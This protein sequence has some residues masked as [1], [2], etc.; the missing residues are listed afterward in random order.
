MTLKIEKATLQ[1]VSKQTHPQIFQ[2]IDAISNEFPDG[3][4]VHLV[5]GNSD[6][7]EIK[8]TAQRCYVLEAADQTVTGVQK[9]LR[10]L[11]KSLDA[12]L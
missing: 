7:L 9:V 11:R 10:K 6:S 2:G 5:P 8:L 12:E 3:W 4:H 1:G